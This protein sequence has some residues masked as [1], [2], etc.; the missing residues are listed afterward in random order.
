MRERTGRSPGSRRIDSPFPAP[1]RQWVCIKSIGS[2][3]GQSYARRG[4]LLQWRGRAGFTP[5]SILGP[6]KSILLFEETTMPRGSRARI[7]MLAGVRMRTC[8]TVATGMPAPLRMAENG[9]NSTHSG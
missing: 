4:S 2:S 8:V 9:S 3:D 6:F 7:V 1:K 5:A